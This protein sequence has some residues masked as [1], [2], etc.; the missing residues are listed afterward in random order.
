MEI[1][2]GSRCTIPLYNERFDMRTMSIVSVVKAGQLGRVLY[3]FLFVPGL[4]SLIN[5]ST[6]IMLAS[7]YF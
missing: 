3:M 5:L 2:L 1:N 4:K 6:Q 7:S